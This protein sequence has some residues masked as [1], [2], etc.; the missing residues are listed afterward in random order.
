MTGRTELHICQ[1]NITGRYYRDKV[2][3]PIAVLYACRHGNADIFQDDNA[4]ARRAN[5]V[6]DYLQFRRATTL[7]WPAKSLDLSPSEHF[8]N[9][10]GRRVQ[11]RCH[12]P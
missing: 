6:Q 9:I 12:K 10:L 2:I 4:R 1:G 11:R 3:G 5:V 7:P 8:W